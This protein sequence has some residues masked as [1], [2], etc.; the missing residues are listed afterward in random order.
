MAAVK[1][2]RRSRE[3]RT[4]RTAAGDVLT[5]ADVAALARE[6]EAGYDLSKA[7]VEYI[8]RRS[9][10]AGVSPRVTFRAGARLYAQIRARA[11]RER[12]SVSELAREAVEQYIQHTDG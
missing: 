6:A 7:R 3:S 11:A 4:W 12:R 1:H 2:Q 10:D 9:L 8:G 5:S